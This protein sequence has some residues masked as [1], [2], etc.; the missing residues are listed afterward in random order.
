[1]KG[2]TQRQRQVLEYVG[3]YQRQR[4]FPP[5]VRD[6]ARH[7]HLVSAAGVHKHIKALVRKGFL[8]KEDYISRSLRVIGGEPRNTRP[9]APFAELPLL[10]YVA[11]GQPIEALQQEHETV[12]VPA[13]LLTVPRGNYVLRVKGNSMIDDCICDGDYVVMEPRETARDGEMVVALVNG[14]EATLKRFYREGDYIRLQPANPS[15]QPILI[16][17]PELRVQGVVVGIWRHYR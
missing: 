1:M 9:M 3:E 14:Q 8:A 2:L 13:E 16:R 6:I 4:G 15:M 7:F 11:A 5:A 10:G 12:T 17:N